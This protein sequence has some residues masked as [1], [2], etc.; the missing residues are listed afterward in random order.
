MTEALV[1]LVGSAAP[2][3]VDGSAAVDEGPA[4]DAV[5]AP[6]VDAVDAPAV[7]PSVARN[8]V[9]AAAENRL[10]GLC[11]LSTSASIEPQ[12]MT[13]LRHDFERPRDCNYS[14]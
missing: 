1:P 5:D 10:E 13:C 7:G 2:G 12:S 6:A 11:V 4:V 3:V 8:D 9:G 14:P